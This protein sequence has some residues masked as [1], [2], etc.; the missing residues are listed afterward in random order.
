MVNCK[1]ESSL[2][3]LVF[4]VGT[5]KGVEG[6]TAAIWVRGGVGGMAVD[7]GD[8][9]GGIGIN[10]AFDMELGITVLAIVAIVWAAVV[11]EGTICLNVGCSICGMGCLDSLLEEQAPIVSNTTTLASSIIGLE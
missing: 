6:V 1:L 8:L 4:G 2:V 11:G 9:V 7:V 3:E 10:S 5:L